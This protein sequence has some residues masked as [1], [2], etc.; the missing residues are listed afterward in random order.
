MWRESTMLHGAKI[1]P[2]R[3]VQPY[4]KENSMAHHSSKLPSGLLVPNKT[5]EKLNHVPLN[6][7]P[8]YPKSQRKQMKVSSKRYPLNSTIS[9]VE[10]STTT[11]KPPMIWFPGG[12]NCNKEEANDSGKYKL[13]LKQAMFNLFR[14]SQLHGITKLQVSYYRNSY[15]LLKHIPVDC[16]S[17]ECIEY[18]FIANEQCK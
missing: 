5:N 10:N 6:T 3:W 16:F 15:W 7:N 9:E 8:L 17:N 11:P 18:H 2:E 4:E 12:N 13:Y 14:F 1:L